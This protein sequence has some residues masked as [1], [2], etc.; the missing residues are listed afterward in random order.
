MPDRQV[1]IL[2]VEP[3]PDLAQIIV[4]HLNDAHGYHVTRVSTA[5]D[6]LGAELTPRHD[7]IIVSL[8]LPDGG[9]LDLVRRLRQ[10]TDCPVLL[11]AEAP[12]VSDVIEALRLG[13]TDLL[14]KPFDIAAL[15]S[16]VGE[17]VR[18]RLRRERERLRRHRLRRMASGIIHERR[19]LRR[20]MDLLCRDIVQSYRR[21]A[22]Q[23]AASHLIRHADEQSVH[24]RR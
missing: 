21:L 18:R 17:A 11:T 5:A 6:A 3:D 22:R 10:T 1:D 24:T 20:R 4:R 12:A 14:E 7:L 15:S 8:D 23:V 16:G 2:V 19:D 13:V 9:G